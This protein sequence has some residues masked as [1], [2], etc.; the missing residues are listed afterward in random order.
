MPPT[1]DQLVLVKCNG[2]ETGMYVAELDR[3]WLHTPFTS[4][5]FL[6]ATQAQL[7]DLRR[8]CDYVYVDPEHSDPAVRDRL[9]H[10]PPSPAHVTGAAHNLAR[11]SFIASRPLSRMRAGPVTRDGEGSVTSSRPRTAGTP[12]SGST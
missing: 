1:T 5:G 6:I 4:R 11:A 12:C 8:C 10:T 7:E 9:L 2:L 3:S